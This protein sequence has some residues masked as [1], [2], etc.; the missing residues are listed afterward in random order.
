MEKYH[1]NFTRLILGEFVGKK[2]KFFRKS[3]II[4]KRNIGILE[5]HTHPLM[6]MS[7]CNNDNNINNF[8]FLSI[9]YAGH[10]CL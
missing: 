7:L 6:Y 1:I 9:Y 2:L 8:Y 10:M 3:E 4:I 5:K